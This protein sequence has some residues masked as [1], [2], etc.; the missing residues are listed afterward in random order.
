MTVN[1]HVERVI[2]EF[3]AQKKPIGLCCISPVLAARVIPGE[4]FFFFE[5]FLVNLLKFCLFF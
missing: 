2:K 4:D 5:I 1:E 3:H